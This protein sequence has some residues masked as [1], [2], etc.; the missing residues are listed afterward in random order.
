MININPAN[1]YDSYRQLKDSIK[2]L[3]TKPSPEDYGRI[4]DLAAKTCEI[5]QNE[6]QMKLQKNSFA[7]KTD[8]ILTRIFEKFARMF[9]KI[10]GHKSK[11]LGKTIIYAV[12]MGN[13]LKDLMTGIVS[14]SQSFTNPDLSKEKR[15]FMGSYDIMAC[16][17]TITLSFILGPLSL[18]KINN[19]YKK[20]LKPLEKTPKY[21]LVLNGLSAFTTI[22]LQAII[23]KRVIAPAISTPLAGIMKNKLQKTENENKKTA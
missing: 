14:T 19:G 10:G 18:N 15:L 8:K 11:D 7:Q 20:L 16:L 3:G 6:V 23:A 2:S 4:K 21:N 17:T 12:L 22:V 5:A 13:I 1:S 9:N